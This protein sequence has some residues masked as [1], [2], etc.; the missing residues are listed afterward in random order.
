MATHVVLSIGFVPPGLRPLLHFRGKIMKLFLDMD[1]V[2]V[3]WCKGAHNLHGVSWT[4]G[5]WPYPT[6]SEGWDWHKT[7]GMADDELFTPMDSAFWANLDW[8]EDGKR[9]LN[10]CEK[11]VGFHN[12]CLLTSPHNL[13]LSVSGRMAWIRSNL[14]EYVNKVLFGVPKEMCASR[15]TILVD[16]YD[17]NINKWVDNNGIGLLLPRPWNSNGVFLDFVSAVDFLEYEIKELI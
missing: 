9:L 8:M 12:I 10:L 13:S 5:V 1:G 17:K 3:D 7:I 2:L 14:P 6:G 4:P 16:D 15:N 11:Y